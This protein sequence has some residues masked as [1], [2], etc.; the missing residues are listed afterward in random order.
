MV[1]ST[2]ITHHLFKGSKI[3]TWVH[4]NSFLTPIQG[5]LVYVFHR[6]SSP[7]FTLEGAR[8]HKHSCT[9]KQT[10]EAEARGDG[11]W[12]KRQ[13][14]VL[15]LT[16]VCQYCKRT[17]GPAIISKCLVLERVKV[18]KELSG[19]SVACSKGTHW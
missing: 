7:Y 3:P 10:L 5:T 12:I 17:A 11:G 14:I 1:N 6:Y 15:Q 18:T 9:E 4:N 13:V 19:R 2:D 8:K 16:E